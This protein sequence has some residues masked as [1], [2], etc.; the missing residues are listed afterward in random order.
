MHWR[1]ISQGCHI[2][3]P[4]GFTKTNVQNIIVIRS[5]SYVIKSIG[6]GW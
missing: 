2:N 3:I 4:L 5:Y 1:A 6:F